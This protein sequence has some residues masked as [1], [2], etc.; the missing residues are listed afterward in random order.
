VRFADA[1]Y[2]RRDHSSFREVDGAKM[3]RADYRAAGSMRLVRAAAPSSAAVETAPSG[4][5]KPLAVLRAGIAPPSG[6]QGRR[7]GATR[8]RSLRDGA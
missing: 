2:W 6:A 1:M 4:R 7:D 5:A 8:L 3:G